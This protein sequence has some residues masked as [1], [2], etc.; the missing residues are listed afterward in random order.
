MP[1][2]IVKKF[3]V[4][5]K[6]ISN[7]FSTTLNVVKKGT[8]VMLCMV[9][10]GLFFAVGCKKDDGKKDN[11]PKTDPMEVEYSIWECVPLPELFPEIT[12]TLNIAE[13]EN[14]AFVKTDPQ[15]LQP[16]GYVFSL[17]DGYQFV[18]EKDTLCLIIDG[19]PNKS[20]RYIITMLSPDSMKLEYIGI[21]FQDLNHIY[22]YTFNRKELAE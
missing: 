18:I 14:M 12:V 8:V 17:N 9:L 13:N 7:S 16:F 6:F 22:D 15:D 5:I 20:N 1:K 2:F 11:A 19:V 4:M 3:I 10:M 21:K